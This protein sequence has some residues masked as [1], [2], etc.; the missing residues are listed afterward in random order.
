M[1]SQIVLWKQEWRKCNQSIVYQLNYFMLWKA[2]VWILRRLQK[3]EG[4]SLTSFPSRLP[5]SHWQL[6][7]CLCELFYVTSHQCEIH[8]LKKY[9]FCILKKSCFGSDI[10]S[11]YRI[12]I[13]CWIHLDILITG[14]FYLWKSDQ[15]WQSYYNHLTHSQGSPQK[16]FQPGCFYRK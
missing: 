3:P 2:I 16:F 8:V 13:H 6:K 11:C 10:T 15:L 14:Q 1:G 7:I 4:V 5:G 12:I 9:N